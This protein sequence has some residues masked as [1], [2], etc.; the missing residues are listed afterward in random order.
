MSFN[1]PMIAF[2]GRWSG[3]LTV[4]AVMTGLQDSTTETVVIVRRP[5]EARSLP[6]TGELVRRDGP[7][8]ITSLSADADWVTGEAVLIIVTNE[9][10]RVVAAGEFV[11]CEGSWPVFRA[12]GPWRPLNRRESPRYATELRAEVVDQ[13]GGWAFAQVM[14]ISLGGARLAVSDDVNAGEV[15]VAFW[16]LGQRGSLPGRVV[17]TSRGQLGFE[18][19]VRFGDL[20]VEQYR[21]LGDLVRLLA[22]VEAGGFG[23]LAS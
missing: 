6:V 23:Q 14:D 18:I 11:D 3:N 2:E 5:G 8:F 22:T 1:E 21:L 19:R 17:S 15:E 4:A 10:Q 16:A 13:D 9:G 20:S 12:I 7:A